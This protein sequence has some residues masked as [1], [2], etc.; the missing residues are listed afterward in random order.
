MDHL[1]YIKTALTAAPEVKKFGPWRL[2]TER[3]VGGLF[4][5][6]FE[7]IS[8]DLLIISMNGQNVIDCKTGLLVFRDRDQKSFD[9]EQLYG[10][11]LDKPE[12]PQIDMAGSCGGGLKRETSDGW[13]VDD[14]PI[15]W[16][17]TFLILQPPKASIYM[18]DPKLAEYKKDGT[19]F[20][21][22]KGI[23]PEVAFGFSWSGKTLLL[24]TSSSVQL[25]RLWI[26]SGD[27]AKSYSH[28]PRS[29]KRLEHPL[30]AT[31]AFP[32]SKVRK[33][34]RSSHRPTRTSW[35]WANSL[36]KRAVC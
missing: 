10:R 2:V 3:A 4:A 34:K 28:S 36:P 12:A 5:V 24:A 8:E 15:D 31:L 21:L 11:R 22:W 30:G 33:N 35:W 1:N 7:R 25:I 18:N 16:P 26:V 13:T 19:F 23:G 29:S 17:E 27:Q 32:G 9:D 20:L 14:F 6:G